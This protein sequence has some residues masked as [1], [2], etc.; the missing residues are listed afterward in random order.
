MIDITDRLQGLMDAG[1]RFAHQSNADGDIVA[2]TGVRTH[3]TVVDVFQMYGE[4]AATGARMS[5]AEPDILSP[6][7]VLWRTSGSAAAVIDELL[8]LD[9][10]ADQSKQQQQGDGCWVPTRP[11]RVAWLRASA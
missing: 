8:R 7:A 11:G 6:R 10:P 1:F 4:H 5:A 2:V 3:H 9:E